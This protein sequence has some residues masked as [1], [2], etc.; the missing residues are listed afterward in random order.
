MRELSQRLSSG[1][2]FGLEN[3]RI[4][5]RLENLAKGIRDGSVLPQHVE[6]A[7]INPQDDFQTERMTIEFADRVLRD[8]QEG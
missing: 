5:D 7:I 6:R 4:A 3:S 8:E 1:Y 2:H